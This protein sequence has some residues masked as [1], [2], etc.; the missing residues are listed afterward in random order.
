MDAWVAHD[1]QLGL[2]LIKRNPLS[3]Q[4]VTGLG[5]GSGR[6]PDAFDRIVVKNPLH[7]E[8]IIGVDQQR[9][10]LIR[11]K[12]LVPHLCQSGSVILKPSRTLPLKTRIINPV[13]RVHK[14][15]EQRIPRGRVTAWKRL[16]RV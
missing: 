14:L 16:L 6:T 10:L 1:S 15:F 2:N 12:R 7:G 11:R 13:L 3:T 5:E 9:L 4:P 8:G